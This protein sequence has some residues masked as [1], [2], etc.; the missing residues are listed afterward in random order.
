M[1]ERLE[2]YLRQ[3]NVQHRDYVGPTRSV[4]VRIDIKGRLEWSTDIDYWLNNSIPIGPGVDQE[5]Y[6]P[7]AYQN[8]T[9]ALILGGTNLYVEGHGYGTF[10]GNGQARY[11]FVNRESNYPRRPHMIVIT[12]QDSTFHGL[13]FVN[14]SNPQ[15][16]PVQSHA[17]ASLGCQTFI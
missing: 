1:Q 14:H 3:Y 2:D 16:G 17:S 7:A 6:P 8:Q 11:D 10:D 4:N 13:R 5:S 12:A 9:T 15:Q